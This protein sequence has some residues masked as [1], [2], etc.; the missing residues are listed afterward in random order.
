MQEVDKMFE[1]LFRQKII[2]DTVLQVTGVVVMISILLASM[3]FFLSLAYNYISVA[4]KSIKDKSVEYFVDYE[5]IARAAVLIGCIVIYIPLV[6]TVVD[7][8]QLFANLT[9]PGKAQTEMFQ[10]YAAAYV[11]TNKIMSA[12]PNYAAY[13][14]AASNPK[15][16]QEIRDYAKRQ[17]DI[18]AESWENPEDMT[19]K[20]EEKSPFPRWYVTFMGIK[21]SQ[22]GL[23]NVVVKALAT[24]LSQLAKA[25]VTALSTGLAKVLFVIGPL[26]FAFSIIPAFRKQVEIWAG[27]FLT[28][29]FVFTTLNVMDHLQFASWKF[30]FG[31]ET[32]RDANII[33]YGHS[34]TIAFD[35]TVFIMYTM[36]FWLTGKYVGKGDA[37]RVMSKVVGLGALA[38]AA[39]MTGGVSAAAGGSSSAAGAAKAGADVIGNDGE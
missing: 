35:I 15:N 38:A 5:E 26:A 1:F 11:K 28:V 14:E 24:L 30:L 16:T 32:I 29:L 22:A 9:A 4:V 3:L 7:F 37:G 6:T 25:V 21:N 12:E 17:M 36:S 34:S 13:A 8:T 23:T 20:P 33:M 18:I 39:A 10:K 19:I 27:T 31:S 2:D